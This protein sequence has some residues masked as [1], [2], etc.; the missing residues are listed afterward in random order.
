[1][2]SLHAIQAVAIEL[3]CSEKINDEACQRCCLKRSRGPSANCVVPGDNSTKLACTNCWAKGVAYL[4]SVRISASLIGMI[5]G[6]N[7]D[8]DNQ[9][10]RK[11][12]QPG[13]VPMS[14]MPSLQPQA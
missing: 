5:C 6:L 14:L 13:G 7:A 1:M 3:F 11:R 10:P 8:R 4:C 2:S 9:V 12:R